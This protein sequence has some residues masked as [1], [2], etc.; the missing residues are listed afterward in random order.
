[1]SH[2]TNI[3]KRKD[4][5]VCACVWMYMVYV[6]DEMRYELSNKPGGE[7]RGEGNVTT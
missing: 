3:D 6:C 4:V 2:P 7:R 1:M 5:H